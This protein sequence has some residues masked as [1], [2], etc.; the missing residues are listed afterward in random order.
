[1]KKSLR[2]KKAPGTGIKGSMIRPIR[3]TQAKR[4]GGERK[5]V[6]NRRD[7]PTGLKKQTTV[8]ENQRWGGGK[9]KLGQ[10]QER[11]NLL[12]PAPLREKIRG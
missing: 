12:K 6:Q 3:A 11:K 4:G 8:S 2:K 5:R 1:V 9:E 10:H 7:D